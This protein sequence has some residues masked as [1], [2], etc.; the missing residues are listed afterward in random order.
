MYD[1]VSPV[2]TLHPFLLPK[3]SIRFQAHEPY[4]KRGCRPVVP[5][6][7]ENAL[8]DAPTAVSAMR[9]IHSDTV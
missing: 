1:T 2:P 6:S 9:R 4:P 3:R 8:S 5:I 7:G